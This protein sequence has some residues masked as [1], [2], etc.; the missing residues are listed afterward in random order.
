MFLQYLQD[1]VVLNLFCKDVFVII[2]GHDGNG[3]ENNMDSQ[4]K[5]FWMT[6][7]L[8]DAEG[9]EPENRTHTPTKKLYN[10]P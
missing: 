1:Q 8:N 9:N 3:A 2:F 7:S 6:R 10:L 5:A 4:K